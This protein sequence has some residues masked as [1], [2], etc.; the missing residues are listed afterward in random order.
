MKLVSLLIKQSVLTAIMVGALSSCSDVDFAAM[1]N[2]SVDP[3]SEP[4]NEFVLKD[5]P[6]KVVANGGSAIEVLDRMDSQSSLI[7]E[8]TIGEK[9]QTT[10]TVHGAILIETG[11]MAQQASF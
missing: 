6:P 11:Y 8:S 1:E 4:K 9:M 10:S 5:E 7:Q 3:F 2:S